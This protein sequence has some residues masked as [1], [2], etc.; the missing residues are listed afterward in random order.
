M[1]FVQSPFLCFL[2]IIIITKPVKNDFLEKVKLRW[3]KFEKDFY[4]FK[5]EY[6]RNIKEILGNF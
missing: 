3:L 2:H 1:L 4:S 5:I 6:G